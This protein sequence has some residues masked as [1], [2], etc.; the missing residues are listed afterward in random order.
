MA[1]Q[2]RRHPGTCADGANIRPRKAMSGET[3]RRRL[4]QARPA[5]IGAF[6]RKGLANG[7]HIVIR[8][9][10]KD[11]LMA[12][13]PLRDSQ[14]DPLDGW[15]LQ[16]WAYSAPDFHAADLDRIFCPHGPGVRTDERR[17]G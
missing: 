15:A 14:I 12:T 5:G 2:P 6:A 16:A 9:Y 4:N 7:G 13:A 17:G 1:Q 3:R 10:N 11:R 8:V